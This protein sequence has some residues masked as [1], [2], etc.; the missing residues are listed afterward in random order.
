LQEFYLLRRARARVSVDQRGVAMVLL[1]IVLPV[2]LAL[3]SLVVSVGNWY[4]HKRHLQTQVDAAAFAGATKFV[5][6]SSLFGDPDAAN[7]AINAA[8]LAYAGDT[9]RDPATANLQVQQAG[10]V[11][12]VLNSAR[13]WAKSDPPDGIG[14]DYTLDHDND[15][16][17]PEGD[18]CTTKTLD[19]K[20]TD[21]EAPTLW[22]WLPFVASPKSKARVEIR[23]IKDQTSM[24]PWAVPEIDPA[25]VV[26]IFVDEDDGTVV[27]WQA[28]M[29]VD[30][31]PPFAEWRT[32]GGQEDVYIGSDNTGIV[33]L[34]SKENPTP[35]MT[36]TL[37][38][39][40]GQSPGLVACYAGA[41][42]TS[43]LSFI[44][45]FS[46]ISGTPSTP[47]LRDVNVQDLTCSADDDSAPYFLL[48]GDCDVGVRAIVDFG[49][50]G[51]PTPGP[52]TGGIGAVVTLDAP[53]CK[54]AGCAMS[55]QGQSGVGT[56]SIWF[57]SEAAKLPASDSP[58]NGR[59]NFSISWKT[60]P[61]DGIKYSGTFSGV[62][63]PYVAN[64]LSGPV[65][66]LELDGTKTDLTPLYDA[67]SVNKGNTYKFV[68]TVGLNRPLEIRDPLDP[69]ILLRYASPS[70]SLN[71]ALDCDTGVTFTNEITNGCQTWYT[72]NYDDWDDNDATPKTW[73]DIT[74][75]AYPNPSDLPPP[76]FEPPTGEAPPNCV[77]AKTGDVIAFRKG[78]AERFE[79]PTCTP[80]NWPTKPKSPATDPEEV[81]DFFRWI[82][83]ATDPRYVTLIV[84][85]FGAFSDS[86]AENEPVK[87]FA[88]F[89]VTG[90]DIGPQNTGC[91][92]ENDPHP[93]GFGPKKDNGDVWGHFVNIVKF[94]SEG[95][96]NTDL[97]NFDEVGN[98]IAVLVE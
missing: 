92:G 60:E 22:G 71:Q 97:C 27:D 5:G 8:A 41:S 59:Q 12:V 76:T 26:A 37:A 52:L 32:Y 21:D 17:T 98:C 56:E 66:Y 93:L 53:G 85:D 55:Y 46:G 72:L 38:D 23:Q 75:S 1:A 90:Y 18:P 87:Y 77:A 43:G 30:L 94:S 58:K 45:G 84:T 89:Y 67:N 62:A 81:D 91:P 83:S 33:V 51:N 6:C 42:N 47:Q 20:A 65:L 34:V 11:H 48:T 61:T 69:P 29:R 86:G 50:N 25:A 49:F 36:G 68:V 40:C 16:L 74:C 4:V 24:L 39:I 31:A 44:H 82:E 7:A 15:P 14:L 13:Y 96:A 80:N 19:V 2:I 35:S 73:A 79:K 70:G 95:K 10:D 3:G 28:L 54:P 88:G 57:T 64:D 9:N 63:H 78:L